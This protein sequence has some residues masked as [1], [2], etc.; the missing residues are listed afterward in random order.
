M[1]IAASAVTRL[2]HGE[3]LTPERLPGLRPLHQNAADR[4]PP[5][6]RTRRPRRDPSA[7]GSR[8]AARRPP[9]PLPLATID[10]EGESSRPA[11]T[12]WRSLDRLLE[13][14]AV[15]RPRG[16]AAGPADT[17]RPRCLDPSLSIRTTQ[18]RSARTSRT[19]DCSTISTTSSSTVA[20]LS[21]RA[22]S[23]SICRCLTPSSPPVF[24]AADLQR[25]ARRPPCRP[26]TR[27]RAQAH[28]VTGLHDRVLD[29]HVVDERPPRRAQVL[30]HQLVTVPLHL[31]VPARHRG[32]RDDHVA[33]RVTAEAE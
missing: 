1:A 19:A 28:D 14:R 10:V 12:T 20:A 26:G 3:V 23:S 6:P 15:L 4:P 7:A 2:E 16:L 31:G 8:P 32:F 17:N 25:R 11:D 13:Q 21:A 9:S 5:K 27:A 22:T 33:S 29:P 24:S 18:P 30:N